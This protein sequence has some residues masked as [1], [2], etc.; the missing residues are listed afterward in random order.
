[1]FNKRLK[2]AL[3]SSQSENKMFRQ[4]IDSLKSEML[5]ITLSPDGVINTVNDWVCNELN[6]RADELIGRTFSDLVPARSRSTNHYKQMTK[7][8]RQHEHWS[9]AVEVSN[10]AQHWVRIILQ[11]VFDMN[12][13]CISI[14][15]FGNNLTRTIEA[16]RENENMISALTRSMAIIEFSP[17]GII[18]SANKLFL[19]TV[20]YTLDD[21][22]GKHHRIFCTEDEKHSQD[23]QNFWQRLNNGEFVADRFKRL[24]KA[25]HI[26]WLE[27]SY[28][29]I[30]NAY[31]ELYKIVKFATDI[32][33]A[34]KREQIVSDAAELAAETSS[35]TG[36][37]ASRGQELMKETEAAMAQLATQMNSASEHINSLEEQSRS[38]SGMVNSIGGIADQTNLLALNAAIEAARAGDQGRGFAVVA[39]EVRELASRT[40]RSTEEIIQVFS[41]TDKLTG[42]SVR[43]IQE[44]LKTAEA[45]MNHI[46]ETSQMIDNINQGARKV[47]DAI[48]QLSNRLE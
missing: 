1:M 25:G 22:K 46:Q 10:E 29:P 2:E 3:F 34:V 11:P 37:F 19:N 17:E 6:F 24:N 18:Q 36:D 44:S 39:D 16:S 20:G 14:D 35:E 32:T 26:I 15:I 5:H 31:G 7:A 13:E 33:P 42:E 27:A 23:Y 30:F 38:I 8:I 28:N 4:I 48:S 45:V 12:G 47:G 41:Q 9:G 21:V 40:S 43:T